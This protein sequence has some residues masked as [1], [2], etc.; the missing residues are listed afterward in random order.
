MNAA[1]STFSVRRHRDRSR[2]NR[3]VRRGPLVV[4]LIMVLVASGWTIMSGSANAAIPFPFEVQSLDGSANT[5]AN[6]SWGR[7]GIIYPRTGPARLLVAAR[8]GT[9]RLI[10][11]IAVNLGD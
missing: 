7:T 6:P 3:P 10:D 4:G 2:G 1:A 11:N 8:V 5:L 9:T